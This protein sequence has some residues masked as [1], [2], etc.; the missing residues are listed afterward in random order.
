MSAQILRIFPTRLE[1]FHL[2]RRHSKS[3]LNAGE[4]HSVDIGFDHN[5]QR[6]VRAIGPYDDIKG[7][8]YGVLVHALMP[9]F[10]KISDGPESEPKMCH[11]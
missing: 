4:E 9:S 8:S 7:N 11:K 10:E 1:P 2:T 3:A 5:L 6:D